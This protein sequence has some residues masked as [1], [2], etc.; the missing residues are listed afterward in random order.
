MEVDGSITPQEEQELYSYYGLGGHGTETQREHDRTGVDAGA[1]RG[2]RQD[3]RDHGVKKGK[4]DHDKD[5]D[6]TITRSEE[7]LKVGT[8]MQAV[9]KARL[10]KYVVT[11]NVTTIVPVEREV[12]RL[13]REP[14]GPGDKTADADLGDDDVEITLSEEVPV[15]TKKRVA[16]E[17]VR[18][19]KDTV[20]EEVQVS[21]E[22][23]K[24]QI[25][26]DIDEGQ[27]CNAR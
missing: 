17:K 6:A 12:V 24:E 3:K 26:T 22:V 10:R 7:E 5:G 13:E 19:A 16:K 4:R 2:V 9:G 21:E 14:I 15:V 25:D 18:L 11:E 8:K 1:D 27:G 20:T 23:K